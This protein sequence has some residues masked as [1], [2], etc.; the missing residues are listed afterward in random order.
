[1]TWKKLHDM[2]WKKECRKIEK[3]RQDWLPIKQRPNHRPP[4][5]FFQHKG[6]T[7]TRIHTLTAT[8]QTTYAHSYGTYS[9]KKLNSTCWHLSSILY[10]Y[11]C[12]PKRNNK[13]NLRHLDHPCMQYQNLEVIYIYMYT[14]ILLWQQ[15]NVNDMNNTA[16]IG[17]KISSDDSGSRTPTWDNLDSKLTN[18][19]S[20]V[21]SLESRQDLTISQL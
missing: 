10:V 9:F 1:M 17:T 4:P 12:L 7:P 15:D 8:L 5:F 6:S 2:I 14:L 19:D 18:G 3:E 11:G 20:Q 21:T 16:I 13:V